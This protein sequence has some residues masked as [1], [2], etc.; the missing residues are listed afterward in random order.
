VPFAR[1]VF[2]LKMDGSGQVKR[3][4]HHHS[5]QVAG[6][7]MGKD[8]FAEPHATASWDGT[9]VAFSSTWGTPWRYDFYTVTGG[10]WP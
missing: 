7:S 3:I 8:Y 10:W 6:G 1:E 5:D 4:A 2:W 9:V